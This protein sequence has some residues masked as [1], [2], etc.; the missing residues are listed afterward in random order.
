[1]LAKRALYL[2]SKEADEMGQDGIGPEHVL[3]GVLRDAQD[4]IGSPHLGR[5][6]RRIRACL[7]LP[8]QGPSPVMLVIEACGMT[9]PALRGEILADLHTTS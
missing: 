9:V 1:M 7:G 8:Q 3:L 2:A 4:P 6:I 5:R